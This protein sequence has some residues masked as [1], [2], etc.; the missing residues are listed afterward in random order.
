M[1]F[2]SSS[3]I[4]CPFPALVLVYV[5]VEIL[6]ECKVNRLRYREGLGLAR[7]C[8]ISRR[9]QRVDSSDTAMAAVQE[10]GSAPCFKVAC[11]L[12]FMNKTAARNL[13]QHTQAVA[14]PHTDSHTR[15]HTCNITRDRRENHGRFFSMLSNSKTCCASLCSGELKL[16]YVC[17]NRFKGR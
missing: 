14:H 11:W 9:A 6:L 8:Q 17:T 12:L 2:R 10:R 1:L 5:L 16:N 7:C 13:N 15:T 4:S 3:L